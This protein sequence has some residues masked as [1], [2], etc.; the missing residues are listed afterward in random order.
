MTSTHPTFATTQATDALLALTAEG[1]ATHADFI[2]AAPAGAGVYGVVVDDDGARQLGVD[3]R[4]TEGLV[5][6]GVAERS[7]RDRGVRAHFQSGRTPDSTLR[8]SLAALLVDELGLAAVP[9]SPGVASARLVLTSD[10]EDELTAWMQQHLRLRAWE[11][12]AGASAVEV[13]REIVREL[14]P[15]LNLYGVDQPWQHLRDRRR[16]VTDQALQSATL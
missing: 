8:R 14:T 3:T 1:G 4:G 13:E 10:S 16:A 7:L 12:P 15:A 6:V 11:A 2:A 5:Y 9:R